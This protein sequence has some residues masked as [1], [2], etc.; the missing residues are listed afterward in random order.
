VSAQQA[1]E[2]GIV[3]TVGLPEASQPPPQLRVRDARAA[4]VDF[5]LDASTSDPRF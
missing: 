5:G 2:L 1:H 3:E 4:V